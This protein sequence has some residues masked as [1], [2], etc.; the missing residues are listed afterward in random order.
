VFTAETAYT[1][2]LFNMRIVL[3]VQMTSKIGLCLVG[4][5]RHKV[6]NCYTCYVL[7][8]SGKININHLFLSICSLHW[9]LMF[10]VYFIDRSRH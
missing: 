4:L 8:F 9:R 6:V 10:I 5:T 3:T 2:C 7:L 1:H